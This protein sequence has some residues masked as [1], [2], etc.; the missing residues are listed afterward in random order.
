MI[1]CTQ[2][3]FNIWCDLTF[4]IEKKSVQRLY[5]NITIPDDFS[6][7]LG[8]E[9]D[10]ELTLGTTDPNVELDR[11]ASSAVVTVLDND[12]TLLAIILIHESR[13]TK[14]TETCSF[15]YPAFMKKTA[16]MDQSIHECMCTI[17]IRELDSFT[18]IQFEYSSM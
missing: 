11:N 12:S 9:R 6:Y 8:P 3:D 7:M 1:T 17:E 13:V 10:V 4:E 15:G 2:T 5:K 18:H 16:R 14:A